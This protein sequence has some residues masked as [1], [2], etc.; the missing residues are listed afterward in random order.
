MKG[1]CPEPSNPGAG[2]K[3]KVRF[4]QLAPERAQ[5]A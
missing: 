5:A 1:E 4:C 3:M 2:W